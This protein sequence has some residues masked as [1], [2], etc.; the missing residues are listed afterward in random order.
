MQTYSML[1]QAMPYL[2]NENKWKRERKSNVEKCNKFKQDVQQQ[3]AGT[4]DGERAKHYKI[5]EPKKQ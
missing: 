5:N 3:H 2:N 4:Y 1:K